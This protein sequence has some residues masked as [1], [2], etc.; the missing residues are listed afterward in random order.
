[1]PQTHSALRRWSPV[2]LAILPCLLSSRP[3]EAQ[4]FGRNKVQY[5]TFDF[6]VMRTPHFDIYFYPEEEAATR[7]AARMA[8]RWYTRLSGILDHEFEQR[9]PIVFYGSTPAFQQTTT[10][11]GEIGE[12]TGGVTEALQQRVI[13]PLTGSFQETDHVVGH[14]L[15]HAF[16]YDISGLGR[17]RGSLGAGARSLGGAPL[18]FIEGMAEYFS[19]GPVDPLTAMWLRDAVLTGNLPTEDQLNNDPR[20]FPYRWGQ[21]LWAYVGGRWGDATVGQILRLVGQGVPYPDAFQQVLNIDLDDLFEDWHVAIRRAYLPMLAERPEAREIARPL[22]TPTKEGSRTNVGP[23]ISPDGRFVAFLA[24]L[25]LDIEL[26][27]ANA[28]TGEI[29]RRLVKGTAFDSHFQSLRFINS[30]GTWSPDSKQFAFSAQREGHDVLVFINVANGDITREV[31]IP[32]VVEISTPSWSPDGRTIVFAGVVGGQSDLYAYDIRSEQTRQLTD[33]LYAELHPSVSPDGSTVAFVTDRGEGTD[34]ATLQYG[35]YHLATMPLAGGESQLVPNAQAGENINPSWTR[36]GSGLF[37]ISNRGGIPNVYRVE[38]ATGRLFQVTRLFGGVSGITDTSPAL[39]VARGDDRLLFTAYEKGGYSIYSLTTPQELAGTPADSLQVADRSAPQTIVPGLPPAPLPA[40]LPPVPRPEQAPFNRVYA[41]LHTPDAG[42]V[43]RDVATSWAVDPYRAHLTLD[44]L[45][46]PSVG[47]A[48]GGGGYAG[49]NGLYGAI[50]GIFSDVLGYHTVLAAVQAQG[51]FDEVGGAFMYL[52]QKHRWNWGAAA[53]RIPYVMLFQQFSIEQ[54][55]PNSG[56]VL[57]N[58]DLQRLRLF[59]TSLQGVAQYPFSPSRRVEFSAGIRRLSQDVITDR[60]TGPAFLDQF[61]NIAQFQIQ[62]HQRFKNPDFSAGYNMA[63]ASA[64]YVYDNALFGYTSP[65]AGQRFRFE[66]SPTV[67]QL[68]FTQTLADFRRYQFFQPFT[69]AVRGMH[70][71]RYGRDEGVFGGQ[72][73]GYPYYM[74][75]YYSAYSE[76]GNG[77][78]EA[79]NTY[80]ELVGTRLAVANVELRFPLIRALVIGP[81]GFPPIEAFGF[82]DSGV[83]WGTFQT[84]VGTGQVQTQSVHPVLRFERPGSEF[85]ADERGILG[86]YGVGGRINLLGFAVLEVDYVKPMNGYRDWHWQFA[87]QPGF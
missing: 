10:L 44:Y 40:Q 43:S 82:F 3:A 54:G 32:G 51:Q 56:S 57:L 46:Q 17:S 66:V 68:Q 28:R 21:A 60:Y 26:W 52:N 19:K 39:T 6:Q 79:C 8:E 78:A 9:Q 35:G 15:V 27:L 70:F 73:L 16:Q 72:F 84:R 83:S 5:R 45:G 75:G 48:V 63:Q 11:Q 37:F 50:S 53:Q 49:Q 55:D 33:D 74:R 24:P 38:L 65:F 29:I 18:W 81:V 86:S 59:D 80:S 12:G 36:D 34:L 23:S 13:L 20:F 58:M 67:G 47:V 87:L 22:I 61:G 71:G 76:C 69:L 62:S 1:M 31:E 7:D 25:D 77:R 2:L 14:E 85:A 64:A 41:M 42:L 4:Y 30:A